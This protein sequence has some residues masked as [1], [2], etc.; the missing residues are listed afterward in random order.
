MYTKQFIKLWYVTGT[1]LNTFRKKIDTII[2]YTLTLDNRQRIIVKRCFQG[3]PMSKS[4]CVLS[5]QK[6]EII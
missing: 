3:V 2:S 4:Q 1:I 6:R 5:V